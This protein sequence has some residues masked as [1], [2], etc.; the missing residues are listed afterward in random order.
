M[1]TQS[2]DWSA[3]L[4]IYKYLR[5]KSNFVQHGPQAS[6]AIN[7]KFIP[8]LSQ[9]LYTL[10]FVLLSLFLTLPCIS[11]WSV[12]SDPVFKPFH[13]VNSLHSS[14]TH[15]FPPEPIAAIAPHTPSDFQPI[16]KSGSVPSSTRSSLSIPHAGVDEEEHVGLV[17]R[18][19]SP[20]V[21]GRPRHNFDIIIPVPRRR[22]PG[23]VEKVLAF[24]IN[25]GKQRKGEMAGLTGKP[26][27]Y[28]TLGARLTIGTL[29]VC[30]WVWGYS[31]L[32]CSNGDVN[33]CCRIWSG[34]HVRYY[35]VPYSMEG[36]N[37]RGNYFKDYFNQPSR[38]QIG[39]MVAILE[40]GAFCTISL[41]PSQL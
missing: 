11:L 30:L 28:D 14:K 35:Y 32:V 41:E 13:H 1:V 12:S 22:P 15:S 21:V 40:V 36:V 5:L 8:S 19:T 38:A 26:L 18:Q 33:L 17:S 29:R 3:F 10:Q 23:V 20:V 37:F 27:L 34:R 4:L 24:I 16:T 39:T 7:T 9:Y 6:L 2:I 25:R 31:F